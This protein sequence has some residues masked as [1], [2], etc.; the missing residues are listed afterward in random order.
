[1]FVRR[2][3]CRQNTVAQWR[4][5]FFVTCGLF[6]L[7][8]LSYLLFAS[9]EEQQWAKDARRRALPQEEPSSAH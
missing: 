9:G 8:G 2:L 7:H 1:M 5:I 3:C 6:V 4:I